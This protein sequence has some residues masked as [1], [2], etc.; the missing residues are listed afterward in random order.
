MMRFLRLIPGT[1]IRPP[2]RILPFP[3]RGFE[4]SAGLMSATS[5]AGGAAVAW[6]LAWLASSSVG[7]SADRRRV[8]D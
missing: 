5:K 7:I 8:I 1:S 2:G 6:A 4:G 3:G